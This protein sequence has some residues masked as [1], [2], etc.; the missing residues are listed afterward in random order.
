MEEVITQIDDLV[1]SLEALKES[2][3]IDYISLEDILYELE[4][5]KNNL[6]TGEE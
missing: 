6:A 4:N 3:E 1:E 2:G 5:L